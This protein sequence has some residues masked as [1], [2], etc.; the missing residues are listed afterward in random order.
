MRLRTWNV[1]LITK[2]IWSILTSKQ[3]L[4]VK[5]IY[6]FCLRGRNFGMLPFMQMR[7]MVG[8][9]LF[10]FVM[11]W[12]KFSYIK[13]VM[14]RPWDC[15]C[16]VRWSEWYW[17]FEWYCHSQIYPSA[18]WFDFGKIFGPVILLYTFVIT[19]FFGLNEIRTASY[20]IVS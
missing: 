10:G 9:R 16:M 2:H 18:L 14:V 3:S 15:F 13:L 20:R 1:A 17:S 8:E 7:V 11:M 12:D 6:A 19:D 5:W 4:Q